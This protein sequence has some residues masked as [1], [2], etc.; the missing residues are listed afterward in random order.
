MKN[1]KLKKKERKNGGE[2]LETMRIFDLLF[3]KTEINMEEIKYFLIV[4]G[5][6]H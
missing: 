6:T 1:K 3:K 2:V 4:M 5:I